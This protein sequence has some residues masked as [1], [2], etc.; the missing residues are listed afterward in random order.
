M[1]ENRRL[2]GDSKGKGKG[3]WAISEPPARFDPAWWPCPAPRPVPQVGWPHKNV[4][5][6]LLREPA[7]VSLV[8][9]KVPVPETP[10]Q[11]PSPATALSLY[12]DLVVSSI[13]PFLVVPQTPPQALGSP[14]LRTPLLTPQSPR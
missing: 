8:L 9:K 10:P 4:V 13:A 6:E 14:H 5:R 2:G 7:R 11:V 12:A 1:R 3:C